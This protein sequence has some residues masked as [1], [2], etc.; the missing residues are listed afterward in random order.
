MSNN[1]MTENKIIYTIFCGRKKYLEIQIKYI[2]KIIFL[3]LIQE[4]HLWAFTTNHIDLEYLKELNAIDENIYKIFYPPNPEKRIWYYYYNYYYQN[5]KDNDIIIKADDDIVYIDITMFKEFIKSI[6]TDA[7]YFPN[8]INNDVCAYY[9]TKYGIHNLFTYDVSLEI[10]KIGVQHPLTLWYTDLSKAIDIHTLFLT[11]QNKFKLN[12][13][14]LISYGNR[15]SIN[16][17]AIRGTAIKKYY[18][19][20]PLNTSEDE[21]YFAYMPIIFEKHKINLN[22][23]VV[24][25]Q[26][27]PQNVFNTLDELFLKKYKLL[28]ESIN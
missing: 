26:F 2:K 18:K 14:N 7:L 17:F 6:N 11:N 4:V 24:H 3:G 20:M 16:F 12:E 13:E 1:F 22:M 8:I 9:Q 27:G 21:S 25:F 15:I 28:S 5:A 19:N 10:N 23:N